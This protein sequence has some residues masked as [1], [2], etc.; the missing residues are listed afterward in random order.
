MNDKYVVQEKCHRRECYWYD[1]YQDMS[2]RVPTCEYYGEYGHCD[3][4]ADCK[5]Y[6]SKQKVNDIVRSIY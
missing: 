3:C 2:A 6:V 1:E 5:H 4:T